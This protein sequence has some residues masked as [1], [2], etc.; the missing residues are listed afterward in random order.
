MFKS[1]VLSVFCCLASIAIHAQSHDGAV[2][3][4]FLVGETGAGALQ[5]QL[6]YT[7]FHRSYGNSANA[8][9][10]LLY[11]GQ[12]KMM[13]LTKEELHAQGLDSALID[14]ARVEALYIVDRTPGAGDI[15][16]I[17]ESEKVNNI[18]DMFKKNIERVTLD[19]GTPAEYRDWLSKWNAYNQ[20]IQAARDAYMPMGN[21]QEA[22]INIYQT[23]FREN[24][25]LTER[26][27]FLR[28][29]KETKD[30]LQKRQHAKDVK[31]SKVGEAAKNAQGRWKLAL[32]S[33]TG[34]GNN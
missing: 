21:R 25:A 11:R 18:M 34:L 27:L 32:A 24:K 4:Q 19:G 26:I 33:V 5:P 1:F 23:V 17:G 16:W 9:N 30:I 28:S 12:M 31:L 10:K 2:M 22:Y 6:Y 13:A 20:A 29:N 7:L 15:A 8:T 14:R 3:N